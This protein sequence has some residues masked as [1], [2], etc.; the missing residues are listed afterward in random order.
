M[1]HPEKDRVVFFQ[2]LATLY[3][4]Y[5]GVLRRLE[6]VYDQSLQPQKRLLL[7]GLLD[8]VM[9]RLLELKS[10]MV[11][12]ESSEYHYLDDILQ[13]LKLTPVR[14]LTPHSLLQYSAK[15]TF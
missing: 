14:T 11:D 7:R 4:R 10:E 3:V 5:V 8:G 12:K 13:D 9:G 15:H 1:P 2:R 6:G